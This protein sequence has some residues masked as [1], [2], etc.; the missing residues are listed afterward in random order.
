MGLIF[1]NIQ[2]LKNKVHSLETFLIGSNISVV[3]LTEH[4]MSQ[5]EINLSFPNNFHC[6]DAF[7]RSKHIRGGSSIFIHNK[8]ISRKCDAINKFCEEFSFEASAIFLDN[9]KLIVISIYHSPKG[10]PYK[11]LNTLE[12]LLNYITQW[13]NYNVVIGGDFNI[14]FD[15][16]KNSKTSKQ[17]L[18]LFRQFNFYHVNN[19]PTRGKNCLD[20]VFV[21]KHNLKMS[22][23]TTFAF[24]FSDHDGLLLQTS[25]NTNNSALSDMPKDC[26]LNVHLPEKHLE[27]LS[28]SLASYNWSSLLMKISNDK[29]EVLF[30][31]IFNVII[32]HLNYYTRA[33]KVKVKSKRSLEK[34]RL[35]KDWFT[36]DLANKK[37]RLLFL[38]SLMKCTSNKDNLDIK[39][40]YKQLKYEYRKSITEAKMV[41]NVN[42]IENSRN[43]CKAAWDVIKF[44]TEVNKVN[45]IN[46][47]PNVL[48]NYFINSVREIKVKT[49]SFLPNVPPSNNLENINS[50]HSSLFHFDWSAVTPEDISIAVKKMNNSNSKDFYSM[51]NNL[52]KKVVVGLVEPLAVC[53]NRLLN[54]GIFPTQ[55]KIS[56][57]S[58][59]YKNGPKDNPQSYRPISIIPVLGKLI[60][61]LV[62]DQIYTFLENNKI[63]NSSQYGFRRGKSTF[64][65]LDDLVR[66]IYTSFEDKAYAQATFCDLSK[67]FD[68]VEHKILLEKLKLYGFGGPSLK[69]FESYLKNRKQT[70]FVMG[71]WSDQQSVE[72][73]VPQGSVLGP[74]LFLIYI[75]DLPSS[76]NSK[77]IL[78]ADDTTFFN[79]SKN[80]NNL[81]NM[82]NETLLHASN[83]FLTNGFLLNTDKTKNVLFHVKHNSKL[84]NEKFENSIK[85]LGIYIDDRLTWNNHIDYLNKRLSRVVYLLNRL[86]D[87]V[88]ISYIRTA[89]FA[90]FQAIIR[91]GL[92][93]YGNCTRITELLILQKKF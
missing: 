7:S 50:T 60:E 91:Y 51:S 93:L 77:T 89:Y 47:E 9:V 53:V 78:Y 2:G 70:V 49:K 31:N 18:N 54:E 41:S 64:N 10:D 33:T 75:N 46:I 42:Y 25:F 12:L 80:I 73:G 81:E 34:N 44:N 32:N 20:N 83:W 62:Y 19:I 65:A 43:K 11:F 40:H 22:S 13:N 59:I 17:L 21:S 36:F 79:I 68:C 8:L 29:S 87:L 14:S 26:Q 38:D 85:F 24:P 1:L 69:F 6:A 92:V 5:D 74:L 15:V 4:W 48:N 88:P 27:A 66:Q 52:L 30:S 72:W 82:A 67:A 71:E 37:K 3:C 57:V 35:N 76:T 16:T 86:N 63:L 39:L 58:P 90:Y 45:K 23:V 55:L 28:L 84:F 56:R 61:Q